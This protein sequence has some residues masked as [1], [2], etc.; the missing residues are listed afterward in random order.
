MA[1]RQMKEKNATVLLLTFLLFMFSIILLVSSTSNFKINIFE[2]RDYIEIINSE[3]I[4]NTLL[5]IMGE[6]IPQFK[7]FIES[8]T[9]Y[10]GDSI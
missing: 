5:L 6:G 10:N 7:N 2:K 4:I 9:F 3:S 1:K 8:D